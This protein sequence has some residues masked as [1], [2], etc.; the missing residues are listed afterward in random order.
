[1]TPDTVQFAKFQKTL[2]DDGHKGEGEK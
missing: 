2:G 1:M